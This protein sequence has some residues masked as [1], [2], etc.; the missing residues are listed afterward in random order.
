ME[1]QSNL[2]LSPTVFLY[3]AG[4]THVT[5]RTFFFWFDLALRLRSYFFDT[6]MTTF[7]WTISLNCDVKQLPHLRIKI[8]SFTNTNAHTYV[9]FEL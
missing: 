7:Y 1:M 4:V 8:R 9:R 6:T 5:L 2:F 3:S